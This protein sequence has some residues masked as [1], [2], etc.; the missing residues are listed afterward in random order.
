MKTYL[1]TPPPPQ[2]SVVAC[3]VAVAWVAAERVF[4]DPVLTQQC[5]WRNAFVPAAARACGLEC[6]LVVGG[7]YWIAGYRKC[8]LVVF[9]DPD[10][11]PQLPNLFHVWA[12][13]RDQEKAWWVD[14]SPDLW[15][16][17]DSHGADRLGLPPIDWV[18]KPPS[19][20]V[21]PARALA[22]TF[23]GLSRDAKPGMFWY[24][25]ESPE[26]LPAVTGQVP[27]LTEIAALAV[28]GLLKG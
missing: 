1:V 26:L 14:L 27:E 21:F 15:P 20:I 8:D 4:A 12:E 13:V 16:S 7:M 24:G 2:R 18:C 9:G 19:Q 25:N 10:V 23:T 17:L 5:W 6:R 22:P 11:R 3:A 28:S